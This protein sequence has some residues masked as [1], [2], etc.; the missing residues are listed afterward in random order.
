M[1]MK[2]YYEGPLICQ[3]YPC[4][5]LLQAN[6]PQNLVPTKLSAYFFNRSCV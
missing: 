5:S 1:L 2:A 3:T 6:S 4:Q